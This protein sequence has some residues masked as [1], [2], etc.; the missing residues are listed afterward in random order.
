MYTY[1][2]S[3]WPRSRPRN[4]NVPHR[5]P[6]SLRLP[7]TRVSPQCVLLMLGLCHVLLTP[8]ISHP[9]KPRSKMHSPYLPKSLQPSLHYLHPQ[10]QQRSRTRLEMLRSGDTMVPLPNNWHLHLSPQSLQCRRF[11]KK[12]ILYPPKVLL[13]QSQFLFPS[14]SL[15]MSRRHGYLWTVRPQGRR[16]PTMRM[17]GMRSRHNEVELHFQCRLL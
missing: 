14:H 5:S 2:L 3:L 10:D 6:V 4:W 8:L 9:I 13:R 16:V 17:A 1:L 15:R 7:A 12:L 11:T